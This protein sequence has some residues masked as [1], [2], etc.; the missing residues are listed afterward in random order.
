MSGLFVA[1]G[2]GGQID[3][4]PDGVT[5]TGRSSST[6]PTFNAVAY[7]GG[8]WVAVALDGVHTSTDGTTWTRTSTTANAWRVA[9]SG[10]LWVLITTTAVVYTSADGLNWTQRSDIAAFSPSLEAHGG[11]F[12]TFGAGGVILR[13][14]DGINWSTRTSGTTETINAMAYGNGRWLGVTNDVNGTIVYSD[15]EGLTWTATTV[16]Y[17][18]FF[19][20]MVSVAYGD[21]QFVALGVMSGGG[22][23]FDVSHDGLTWGVASGSGGFIS[24]GES[25]PVS[26]TYAGTWVALDASGAAASSPDAAT[27]TRRG[28]IGSNQDVFGVVL[29]QPPNAPIVSDQGPFNRATTNR[30]SWQFSDPDSGDSQ[31]A[32]EFSYRPVGDAFWT[33]IEIGN[34]NQFWDA[35][36]GTFTADLYEAQVRTADQ[37]GVWG[38]WSTSFWITAADAPGGPT[39]LDPTNGQTIPTSSYTFTVSAPNVDASEFRIVADDGA[40]NPDEATILHGPFTITSGN[41][42]SY[43][44]N[45]LVNHVPLHPQWRTKDNG[46]YSPWA[47]IRVDVSYTPPPAPSLLAVEDNAA[48]SV[49]IQITNPTPGTGEPAVS[50]NHLFVRSPASAPNA[51]PYRPY[52]TEG[53]RIAAMVAPNAALTDPLPAAGV[54]YEYRVEAH[55][56]NSTTSDSGWITL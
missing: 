24:A 7:G 33:T 28:T 43:T 4:S 17:A 56:E 40:G 48:A 22:P 36:A 3:T 50:Y 23:C 42:R 16:G 44:V 15:D 26:V 34:P 5:W 25:N 30:V 18:P 52:S 37:S 32:A 1:V 9:Y 46:L 47:T 49:G 35:P 39:W 38:P 55:G 19:P 13:S 45:G 14:T 53:T 41:L 51:D 27:W 20:R 29:N 11:V 12:L 10:G 8:R 31:S 21:G 54:A 6:N 2:T